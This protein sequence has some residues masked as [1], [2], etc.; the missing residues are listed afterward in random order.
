MKRSS[1]TDEQI[2]YA[3]RQVDGEQPWPN[4]EEEV[5]ELGHHRDPR[6]AAAARREREAKTPG[7]RSL[8]R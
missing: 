3:L 5:R 8:A 1:F 4:L 7:G 6:A 2:A